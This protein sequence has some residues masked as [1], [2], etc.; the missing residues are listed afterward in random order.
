MDINSKSEE[1]V[2]DKIT[3]EER[4]KKLEMNNITKKRRKI[5]KRLT[6][7]INDEFNIINFSLDNIIKKTKYLKEFETKYNKSIPEK[8]ILLI[9]NLKMLDSDYLRDKEEEEEEEEVEFNLS[10]YYIWV[11]AM[12]NLKH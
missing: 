12:D 6:K 4:A 5:T 1:Q 2:M 3:R 11:I 8:I 10:L 9:K 7:E